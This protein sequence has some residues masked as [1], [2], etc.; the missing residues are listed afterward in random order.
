MAYRLL[1]AAFAVL[2]CGC[3]IDLEV[4]MSDLRLALSGQEGITAT[5]TLAT[6]RFDVAPTH[7]NCARFSRAL[8]DTLAPFTV[9][10]TIKGC[11]GDGRQSY[12]VVELSVPIVAVGKGGI[13]SLLAIFV[14]SMPNEGDV[15]V[16]WAMNKGHLKGITGTVGWGP[17]G[18]FDPSEWRLTLVVNNDE[19]GAA[20]VSAQDRFVNRTPVAT[21]GR[22]SVEQGQRVEVGLSDVAAAGLAE[23]GIVGAFTLHGFES[24]T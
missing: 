12:I 3:K 24:G 9:G 21:R 19:E 17:R 16:A 22:F 7:E 20:K 5:A 1:L 14:T 8:L 13:D 2:L 11:H 4:P 18:N 10:A 23:N 15:G 6:E